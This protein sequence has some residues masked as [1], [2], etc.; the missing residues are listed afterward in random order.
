[1]ATTDLNNFN[2]TLTNLLNA[3][4]ARTPPIKNNT[5]PILNNIQNQQQYQQYQ[6]Y[7]QQPFIK[8]DNKL[9]YMVSIGIFVILILII[10]LIYVLLKQKQNADNTTKKVKFNDTPEK[11]NYPLS[12]TYYNPDE[13][14]HLPSDASRNYQVNQQKNHQKP[15]QA[16]DRVQPGQV[17][18]RL[19][20]AP[21]PEQTSN[22]IQ[23]T[24]EEIDD[25]LFE[26]I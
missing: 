15:P 21:A 20:G 4:S 18:H 12:D 1:M 22:G 7:Q 25:P 17:G 24:P 8:N 16:G 2:K 26:P 11:Y 14:E 6:Q 9:M 19:I 3:G 23:L 13:Q 5:T 10:S